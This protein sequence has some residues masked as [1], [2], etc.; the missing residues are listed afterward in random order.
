[1]TTASLLIFFKYSLLYIILKTVN[2]STCND[3]ECVSCP[4]DKDKCEQCKD[5][6]TVV[7]ENFRCKS[8]CSVFDC[9]TCSNGNNRYHCTDCNNAYILKPSN[10]TCKYFSYF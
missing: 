1:M 6:T 4:I 8:M 7:N 5:I 2:S 9:K 3:P 10:T